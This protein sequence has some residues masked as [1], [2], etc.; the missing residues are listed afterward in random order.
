ML[1]NEGLGSPKVTL[2]S[3]TVSPFCINVKDL[4]G[5][6]GFFPVRLESDIVRRTISLCN[7]EIWFACWRKI[8]GISKCYALDD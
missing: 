1:G 5:R 3:P 7:K 8:G 6:R 2:G 4:E